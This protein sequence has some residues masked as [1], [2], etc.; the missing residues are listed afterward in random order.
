MNMTYLE[1]NEPLLPGVET[2]QVDLSK[3]FVAQM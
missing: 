2:R 1:A 3:G